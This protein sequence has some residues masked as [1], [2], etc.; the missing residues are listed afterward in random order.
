FSDIDFE[1]IKEIEAVTQHDV[2][3]IELF[4]AEKLDTIGLGQ[5]KQWVHFG[6][7]SEDTNNLAIS[8]QLQQGT[9]VLLEALQ[10]MEEVVKRHS[11]QLRNAVMLARTHGQPAV[12]T[13]MG[14]ELE[15]HLFQIKKI[16]SELSQFVYSGKLNGAVGT[17]AAHQIAFPKKNWLKFSDTYISSLG[18]EPIHLTTQILPGSYW[19]DLFSKLQR[20]SLS[21]VSLSQDIWWYIALG[22]FKQHAIK[23]EVGS[24]T[25]PQKVNPINFENAEGN[26]QMAANLFAFFI[27]KF[28]A[29]RLQRDLSDSTVRRN[30]GVAYGHLLL[31][32]KSL[33]LGMEKISA[34]RQHMLAE[35]LNHPEVLAEAIQTILRK[36][37]EVEA[38]E[39]IKKITRNQEFSLKKICRKLEEQSISPEAVQEIA[40]LKPEKYV[41]LVEK[42]MQMDPN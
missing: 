25:M 26:A 39:I 41:G 19:T 2:K 4:I 21:L 28:S 40:Q 29:T 27:Q 31:A 10:Q 16:K 17:M 23:S 33:Q 9:D 35:V 3:A 37:G 30:F 22:Y 24:S 5:N 13:T 15:V 11:N 32:I 20:I 38:Y 6:L 42:I 34:D 36:H 7:T 14:K 12:P 18:F 8:R 1:R